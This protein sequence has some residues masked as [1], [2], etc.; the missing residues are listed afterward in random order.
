M[1]SP[2]LYLISGT[3]FV[4]SCI[5]YYAI[6]SFNKSDVRVK[7]IWFVLLQFM[8]CGGL[9]YL[10]FFHIATYF[11]I[12]VCIAVLFGMA[13]AND[14]STSVEFDFFGYVI[15]GVLF[16]VLAFFVVPLLAFAMYF[17]FDEKNKRKHQ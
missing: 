11:E 6:L 9:L 7:D 16:A 12:T 17:K 14:D 3:I 8:L 1:H 4:V 10:L 15:V 13:A 2:L 5:L